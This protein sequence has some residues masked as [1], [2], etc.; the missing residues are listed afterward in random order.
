MTLDALVDE[1]ALREIYLASFEEAVTEGHPW[2][3]MAAYNRLNGTY[4]TEHRGLLTGILR[5]EWG[6][7]G[8]VMSDWGAVD[9]RGAALEAGLDLSMPGFGGRGDAR[10]DCG[11]SPRAGY[12]PRPSTWGPAGSWR[13]SPGRPPPARRAGPRRAGSTTVTPTTSWPAV[14]PSRRWWCSRT[15]ASSR[16]IRRPRCWSRGRSRRRHGSRAPAARMITPHRLDDAWTELV[17]LTRRVR[18][19]LRARLPARR[20]R[21]RRGPAR[22]GARGGPVG[23]RRARLR[24]P[25]RGGGDRGHRPREPAAA[26][27]ARRARRGA[28]RGQPASRGGARQRCAGRDAVG[29]ARARDRRG[30]PRRPGRRERRRPRAHRR[31]GARRAPGRDVPGALDGQPGPRAAIRAHGSPSTARACTSATATTTAS[32]R[33]S[34]SRSATA[35]PTRRSPTRASPC[36]RIP[37]WPTASSRR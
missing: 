37:R 15:T 9:R 17:R 20:R 1:R 18:P 7:D 16:S 23:G 22:R 25:H 19:G 27:R 4:C 36:A 3:V 10:R 8:A 13:S 29:L 12:R 28:A 24:R 14:R 31:G 32:G 2:T 5:D 30:L 6:F 34:C 21:G 33:T 26:R 35:S 11:R